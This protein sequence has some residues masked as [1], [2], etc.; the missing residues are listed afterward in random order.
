MASGQNN[1]PKVD[2][3]F[4]KWNLSKKKLSAEE[5]KEAIEELES[6]IDNYCSK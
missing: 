1:V 4:S 3:W 2:D 6:M 5:A